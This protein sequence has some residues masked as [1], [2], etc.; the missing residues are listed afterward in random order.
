MADY[1]VV[2]AK[3][4]QMLKHK[5]RQQPKYW[6]GLFAAFISA[7]CAL[8]LLLLIWIAL[9]MPMAYVLMLSCFVLATAI[10][11][12][13]FII[14]WSHSRENDSFAF[15]DRERISLSETTIQYTYFPTRSCTTTLAVK[16]EG[17]EYVVT[18]QLFDRVDIVIDL[19]T[20]TRAEY[21]KAL[22]AA[23]MPRSKHL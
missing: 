2:K 3:K 9:E 8:A 13:E 10:V 4:L 1:F 6:I 23:Y 20:I 7:A 11:I 22:I 14:M 16:G 19:G 18:E 5:A 15:R 17:G 21:N 12:I